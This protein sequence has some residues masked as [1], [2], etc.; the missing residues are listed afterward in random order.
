MRI[1]SPHGAASAASSLCAGSIALTR[2]AARIT[3]RD[4]SE[5]T[6]LVDDE[7]LP[8]GLRF[9]GVT[10][11]WRRGKRLLPFSAGTSRGTRR[12]DLARQQLGII[13]GNSSGLAPGVRTAL[14]A[15]WPAS[16]WINDARRRPRSRRPH[17]SRRRSRTTSRRGAIASRNRRPSRLRRRRHALS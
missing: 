13:L 6:A 10:A 12:R 7:V 1:A 3:S 14:A 17:R 2:C 4:R 8:A 9:D 16:R 11:A 15:R 5:R